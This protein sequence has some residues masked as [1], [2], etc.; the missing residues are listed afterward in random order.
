MA[1][2]S[3]IR[4][5]VPLLRPVTA[6]S[7]IANTR[8][9]ILDTN[10]IS[11]FGTEKF[12]KQIVEYLRGLITSSVGWGIA[13][14]GITTFECL[15]E[16]PCAGEA[17][18]TTLLNQFPK[19]PVDEEALMTAAHLGSIYKDSFKDLGINE[20][21]PELG[22]K[23][24]AASAI[25]HNGWIC[26]MN[27]RDFPEPFFQEKMRHVFT[28][29]TKGKGPVFLVLYIVEPQIALINSYYEKRTAKLPLPTPTAPTPKKISSESGVLQSRAATQKSD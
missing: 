3:P 11:R 5:Q 25:I 26:T 24:I 14:S 12:G 6:L 29:E 20:G 17:E 23:L 1:D 19:Y 16:V 15:N 9:L 28:H 27:L 21:M 10:V 8:Y 22:D 13:L 4:K 18:L 2:H 7:T